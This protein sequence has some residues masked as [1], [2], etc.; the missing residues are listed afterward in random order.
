MADNNDNLGVSLFQPPTIRTSSAAV[1]SKKKKSAQFRGTGAATAHLPL[2][3][4]PLLPTEQRQRQSFCLAFDKVL[5]QCADKQKFFG[6]LST[7]DEYWT[8][9]D[10]STLRSIT[11]NLTCTTKI[12]AT[13]AYIDRAIGYQNLDICIG[14]FTED[15]GCILC[16]LLFYK[17]HVICSF[18]ITQT[19]PIVL[20]AHYKLDPATYKQDESKAPSCAMRR[21]EYIDNPTLSMSSIVN[22]PLKVLPSRL[23]DYCFQHPETIEELQKTVIEENI[24]RL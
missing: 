1:P 4:T 6:L 23:H 20:V 8:T 10:T 11:D 24:E 14:L 17:G 15:L 16:D 18:M 21:L 9:G 7:E 19:Q 22:R 13:L 2:Q 5:Q 3:S 12:K